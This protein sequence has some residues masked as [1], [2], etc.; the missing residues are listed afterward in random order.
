MPN[1][2]SGRLDLVERF[3][4]KVAVG[5]G[6]W[7]WTAAVSSNGY[8]AIKKPGGYGRLYAHRVAYELTYGP[9]PDGFYVCHRCDNPPCCN[10]SHLFLGAPSDNTLDMRR[11]RRARGRPPKVSDDDVRAMRALCAAGASQ[12]E[13]GRHYGIS[14]PAVSLILS[15]K[16]RGSVS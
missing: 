1:Q 11:K 7:L 13:A 10:P 9:I 12:S 8:G 15:G 4:P 16:N 5:A 3:W 2:Y 14:Q 6:C